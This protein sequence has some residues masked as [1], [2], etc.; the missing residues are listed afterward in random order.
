VLLN[1]NDAPRI[2]EVTIH[3]DLA[4]NHAVSWVRPLIGEDEIDLHCVHDDGEGVIYKGLYA[5]SRAAEEAVL[6]FVAKAQA[7]HM[8]GR[9]LPG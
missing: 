5:S 9:E 2:Y 6:D 7:S 3:G 1:L 8:H 4:R